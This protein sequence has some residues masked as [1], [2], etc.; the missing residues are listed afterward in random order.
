MPGMAFPSFPQDG[1]TAMFIAAQN[2]RL[3]VVQTLLECNALVNAVD[4]VRL[5][6]IQAIIRKQKMSRICSKYTGSDEDPIG[7]MDARRFAC[8]CKALY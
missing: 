6:F 8:V 5:V 4:K 1:C 7:R 2:G 3:G